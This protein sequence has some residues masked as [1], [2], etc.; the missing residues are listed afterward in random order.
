VRGL[1]H[2]VGTTGLDDGLKELLLI[3]ILK[4]RVLGLHGEISEDLLGVGLVHGDL[5]LPED[6]GLGAGPGDED[7]FGALRLLVSSGHAEVGELA[8]VLLEVGGE[9]R[10]TAGTGVLQYYLVTG[11]RVVAD[12]SPG[13]G[14]AVRP[15]GGVG[16]IETGV[17][18]VG[19][20]W[21]VCVWKRK[22]MEW[23]ETTHRP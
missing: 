3:D 17:R 5:G 6:G 22:R 12:D 4:L 20:E 21:S 19:H 1:A 2:V 15:D 7:K 8:G 16:F 18:D 13:G 9:L 23:Q 11:G 10:Q 14:V